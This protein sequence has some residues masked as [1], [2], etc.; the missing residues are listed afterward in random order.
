MQKCRLPSFFHTSTMALHQ[1][2]RL[3]L[4][5]LDSNISFRWF[6][7]SSTIGG[8]IHLNHSLKG[9]LLVTF[10]VCSVEWVQPSSNGSNENMS[11]YSAR[12]QWAAFANSGAHESRPLKS[13][14]LNSL[15]CLC[16]TFSFGVW[17]SG[18]YHF[19]LASSWTREAQALALWVLHWPWGSFFE[20]FVGR[21]Y[22]STPLWL[23]FYCPSSIQCMYS[24][25]WGLAAR[26]H[27]VY[28]RPVPLH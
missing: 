23:L 8:G 13:S 3:G 6:L 21:W 10:I 16:L 7:T 22:Y 26:C 4:M 27:P 12:S 18:L 25:Q 15:P 2:L 24:V 19:Y 1:A 14:S 17:K 28:V 11:W 9:V 5:A 20:G